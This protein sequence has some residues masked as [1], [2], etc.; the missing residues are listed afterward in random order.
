MIDILKV[1]V[2]V[3]VGL[4]IL[5]TFGCI[6]RDNPDFY[7]INTQ[8]GTNYG[9]TIFAFTLISFLILLLHLTDLSVWV[10]AI[11]TAFGLI[12]L[13][14]ILYSFVIKS[15]SL[16]LVLILII[17]LGVGIS[18]SY[19]TNN[20]IVICIICLSILIDILCAMFDKIISNLPKQYDWL[21]LK[22]P[23]KISREK[24]F[25]SA[26]LTI[27]ILFLFINIFSYIFESLISNGFLIFN[28]FFILNTYIIILLPYVFIGTVL[29]NVLFS[30]Y[31]T[32]NCIKNFGI[33]LGPIGGILDVFGGVNV[34]MIFCSL[35]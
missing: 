9:K 10:R 6:L 2:Q 3:F 13:L 26:I 24:N 18:I 1:M 22:Y 14:E 34:A 20:I 25:I 15:I 12:A 23:K 16:H 29:G 7:D 27:F 21:K 32:M 5:G 31:K 4:N 17:I 19:I 8:K 35:L 11:V 33:L 28:D 30:Y